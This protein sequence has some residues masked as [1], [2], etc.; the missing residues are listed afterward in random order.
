[1]KRNIGIAKKLFIVTLIVFI[2]FISSALIFQSLFFQKFY[3]HQKTEKFNEG[4]IKFVSSYKESMT[5]EQVQSLIRKYEDDYN[6]QIC[7]LDGNGDILLSRGMPL[8]KNENIKIR[9]LVEFVNR[10]VSSSNLKKIKNNNSSII[11]SS[12]SRLGSTNMFRVTNINN[13][14]MLAF[15]MVSLQPVDEAASSMRQFFVYFYIAAVFFIIILSL[16]YSNMI[17]KPLIKINKSA[18]K[19]ANLDFSEKCDVKSNDEIGNVAASMN[20]LST[21]LHTALTSLKDAN[22]KLQEDIEKERNLEKNRKEF[23]AAVSHELKTPISL[24]DGYAVGLKDEIFE[25]EDK[26]Y[27]LDIIIDEAR[28]MSG[29]VSDMLDLSQLESGSFKLKREEFDLSELLCETSKKYAN[30]IEDKGVKLDMMLKKGMI[31]YAD[32]NRMEQVVTNF[33]TNAIRFVNK[34]GTIYVRMINQENIVRCEIENTGSQ[35]DNEELNKIWDRFYKIDKSRNRKLGG[36]GVGLS[37]VKNI[38]KLHGY[39]YGVENT[40]NGVKFYFEVTKSNLEKS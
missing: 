1:M 3:I 18:T 40:Q 21:N 7:M 25:G 28:K 35:I 29:L 38:L 2:V 12:K 15:G 5:D 34:N 20:F 4:M 24:I 6:I 27:Y 36:T 14:S 11:V 26:D 8:N 22:A 33:M 16:I 13:F 17:S 30:I 23:V 10:W 31:I 39:N 19:M 32:W 9:E 37:I